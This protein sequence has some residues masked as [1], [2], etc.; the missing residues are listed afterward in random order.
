MSN[1][2]NVAELDLDN[3]SLGP[4]LP[5][6]PS[7][8]LPEEQE[9][10]ISFF[11]SQRDSWLSIKTGSARFETST[12]TIKGDEYFEDKAAESQTGLIEFLVEPLPQEDIGDLS[13]VKIRA[14]MLNDKGWNF[15]KENVFD[16][17][18]ETKEWAIYDFCPLEGDLAQLVRKTFCTELLFFPF[19]FM[20][21]TFQDEVWRN[22][23]TAETKEQFFEER[24]IPWRRST[25][26]E[27]SQLFNGESH[28]LFMIS[29]TITGAHYWFNR[30]NGELRRVDVFLPG[31]V[32]KSFQYEDYYQYKNQTA[33]YPR[34][35]KLIWKKGRGESTIGW[36]FSMRLTNVALNIDIPE[37]NFSPPE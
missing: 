10:A 22:R 31:N 28:Y 18:E 24:G 2:F 12:R 32:V 9:K 20:S 16:P 21:K 1:T 14:H 11:E 26:E 17:E 25:S 30:E 34:K 37:D 33:K 6:S 19:D 35:L 23:Y 7:T 29:P 5:S 15:V 3:L 8:L 4:L 36:E 13:P 27:D